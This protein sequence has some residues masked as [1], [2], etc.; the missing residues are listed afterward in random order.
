MM[1]VGLILLL[2]GVRATHKKTKGKDQ[3]VLSDP[4]IYCIEYTHVKVFGF[5]RD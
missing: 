2:G 4:K 5:P 3:L 1:I